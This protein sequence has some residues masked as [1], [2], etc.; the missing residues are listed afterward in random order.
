MQQEVHVEAGVQR[1]T[2]IAPFRNEHR[3]R[4]RFVQVA[5]H[6]PPQFRRPTVFRILFD[7]TARHVYAEAVAT[8][9]QPKVHDVLNEQ[10]SGLRFR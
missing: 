9:A 3:F 7:Q 8:Q 4:V 10:A 1:L 6:L 5:T 2:G